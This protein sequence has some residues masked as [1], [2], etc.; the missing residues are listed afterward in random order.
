MSDT[1]V[2]PLFHQPFIKKRLEKEPPRTAVI[3]Q[4]A[5]FPEFKIVQRIALKTKGGLAQGLLEELAEFQKILLPNELRG[6]FC[7]GP[8]EIQGF[9]KAG[10]VERAVEG[11][12]P[13][14]KTL[15]WPDALYAS[16]CERHPQ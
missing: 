11:A 6:K 12:R 10:Q 16:Y 2:G 7:Q 3:H 8:F 9:E 4:Q 14:S 1:R 13:G 5:P 15:P